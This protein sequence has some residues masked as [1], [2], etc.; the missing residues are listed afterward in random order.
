MRKRIV[1]FLVALA[2]SVGL[3]WAADDASGSCG[4][5]VTYSFN[6]TTGAMVISGTGAMTDYSDL[7]LPPWYY[8]M[9]SITSVVIEAGVTHVGNYAFK[10]CANLQ[11]VTVG[12]DV[13]SVGAYTFASAGSSFTSLS[14]GNKVESIG[15]NAFMNDEWLTSITL[16]SSLHTIGSYAF[17]NC[18]GLSSITIPAGVTSI[19]QE[20]FA[21]CNNLTSI[22]SEAT[23]PPTLGTNVFQYVPN[24]SSVSLYV[25]SESISAYQGAAQWNT[26]N[27]QAIAPVGPT[28]LDANFAI[29]F[30]SNP[31]A[32]VVGGPLPAVV[33]V[34]G[35]YNDDQHGYRL[36]VVTVPVKAGRY[37]VTMGAC[38]YS[39]QDGTVKNEDGSVTYATLATNLGENKCYH[40]NTEKNIVAALFTVPSDQVIKIYGAEYTPY[41]SIEKLLEIPEFADFEIDF[42]KSP[43]QV[44]YELP[45]GTQIAGTWHDELHGY[46][47]VVATVPLEAGTYRLTLGACQYGIGAGNVMSDTYVE[48]ASFNQNLGENKCYHQYRREYIVSMIFDVDVDQRITIHCGQYTPYMKLQKLSDSKYYVYFKNETAGVEGTVPADISVTKTGTLTLPINKKLYKE[49][50]TLTGWTDGVNTYAPGASFT[51]THNT[52]MTAVFTE[53]TVSILDATEEV[54]VKWYFSETDGAPS[55]D[56]EG[57]TGLLVAQTVVAGQKVDVKLGIDATAEDSRF[58]NIGF[59]IPWAYVYRNTVFTYPYKADAI[60]DVKTN[61][62]N[63]TYTLGDGTLTCTLNDLYRYLELTFPAPAPVGK[64]LNP[65]PDPQNP[66]IYYCT[67][68]D[69]QV[70]YLLPEGVEAYV[71]TLS[72]G[73]LYLTKIADEGDVIPSDNAVIFK[74]TVKPFTITPSD[75]APV[76][77]MT[78]SLQGTDVAIPTP[79][80][81]YVLSAEDN[82]VGFYQYGPDYLNP[83]KAYVIY[84]GQNL[85]PRRMRFI[86]NTAT[87]VEQTS[88]E[89]KADSQKMLKDGQL[90]II[91]NGVYY[92]VQGQMVK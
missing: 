62:G 31:Y 50:Y 58:Y 69:S 3:M 13:V 75:E 22:T 51:P 5:N 66:A 65:N 1:T 83:N 41:I 18:F 84:S 45:A 52:M 90:I 73:D 4:E 44:K 7:S 29:D 82:Y 10:A 67:F 6:G 38:S 12:N 59:E 80:N 78:N 24:P 89:S 19:G 48:L 25:P 76:P 42:R 56:V 70:K 35:S 71:A 27:I 36:P 60:V 74:S 46:E 9:S 57:F 37:K 39:H 14:M 63:A 92:N 87:G 64:V 20:A 55:M 16:P 61:S 17:Y 32:V 2:A 47:N 23:T 53:N 40:Q 77:V 33:V 43:Y 21:H 11:S 8:S 86:F 72:E 88:Q 26:F 81:C 28:Y 49:G 85:A 30:R 91:K 34:E 68:Y 54:S 79:A 15:N